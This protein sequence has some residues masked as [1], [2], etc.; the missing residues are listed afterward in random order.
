MFS[1]FDMISDAPFIY[2]FVILIGVYAC[3]LYIIEKK[4]KCALKK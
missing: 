1:I 4:N 3:F 2:K